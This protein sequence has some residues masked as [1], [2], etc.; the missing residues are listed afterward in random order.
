MCGIIRCI[1]RLTSI[2]VCSEESGRLGG[3]LGA[4][5]ALLKGLGAS[6]E[7]KQKKKHLSV[8]ADSERRRARANTKRIKRLTRYHVTQRRRM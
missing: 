2:P 4:V 1:V 7:K 5:V 6:G 3:V 8:T